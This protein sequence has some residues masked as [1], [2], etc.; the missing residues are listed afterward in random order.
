MFSTL[1]VDNIVDTSD[2]HVCHRQLNP[3]NIILCSVSSLIKKNFRKKLTYL[4]S[5][6]SKLVCY[7]DMANKASK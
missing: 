7:W 4:A 2:V 6:E 5:D 1:L 3:A